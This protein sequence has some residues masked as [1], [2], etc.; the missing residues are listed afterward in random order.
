MEYLRPQQLRPGV[1][2]FAAR[3]PTL[4]PATHTNSYALGEREVILVEPATPH[5]DEQRAWLAWAR[6]LESDGRA[7]RAIFVTH[8]HPDHVGGARHFSEALRLPLWGH[9]L[10]GLLA[11][12]PLARELDDGDVLTLDGPT[13]QRWRCLHTPG[14]AAGHLCLHEEALDV[15][16]VGDM[17]ASEGTILIAPSDGDLRQYLAQLKRLSALDA[18]LALPAHGAP[19]AA[20]S[21]LFD[22][23]VRHRLAREAKVVAALTEEPADLDAL[24]AEA[25]DD[26]PPMIWPIAKLSLESHLIKLE[27]DG[28]AARSEAGWHLTSP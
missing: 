19:I 1:S 7:L 22:H 14:H 24:V 12:L 8:H 17:V 20:P 18:G 16:V 6:G 28:R 23:Y 26:T 5:E 27:A 15:L 2:W 3:T 21:A 10:T 11:D 4:P 25:Y 13:P 9:A